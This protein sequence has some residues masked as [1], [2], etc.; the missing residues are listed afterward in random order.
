MPPVTKSKLF[1]ALR[2]LAI[3]YLLVGV[4][5]GVFQRRIIYFPFHESEAAMLDDARSNG[6]EAWRD[7]NKAIIGWK[8]TRHRDQPAANRL[9]LF[10]G[11]TGYALHRTHYLAGFEQ[12]E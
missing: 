8:S 9:V 10:H 11:N 12:L 6:C 7:E 1:R 4:L 2:T 5:V 3:T